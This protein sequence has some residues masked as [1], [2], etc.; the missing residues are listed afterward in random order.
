MAIIGLCMVAAPQALKRAIFD[1]RTILG[2]IAACAI[3]AIISSILNNMAPVRLARQVIEIH[4]QAAASIVVGACMIRVCG[5][6]PTFVMFATV[7]GLST[8]LALLQFLN[9]GQ[10]WAIRDVFQ[11]MQPMQTA[12]DSVFL[13]LR[14]RAMGLS[15]S[16]VHLGTQL[17]LLFAA[18]FAL[19]STTR[20]RGLLTTFDMRVGLL[21]LVLVFGCVISGN[22]SPLIGIA[23]FMIAYLFTVKP[24]IALTLAVVALPLVVF[25][26]DIMAVLADFGLRVARTD[27]GSAAGRAILRAFGV[28]LFFDRPYGYG[29][30]F[31]SVEHWP[32]YWETLS[33]YDNPM[34]IRIHALHNYY[35]MILNKYGAPVVIVA[36]YICSKIVR[37]KIAMLAFTPYA[38]HIFYHNEGPMQGDFLIW[39]ILPMFL[40]IY[41]SRERRPVKQ[42][43][44]QS[45][46]R[47]E[48]NPT[49][50]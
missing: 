35:L 31:Q 32:K 24:A 19:L 25:I 16:P 37:N 29:L 20:G 27:D 12:E 1:V 22:R 4:V 26:D 28:L 10:A 8:A 17:C 6:T 41:P 18:G 50:G 21:A 48:F 44:R 42:I 14:L 43:A 39:F 2:V 34:A 38:V 36:A 47:R 45:H 33:G 11:R 13:T 30:A 5:R 9:V 46:R 49:E 23:V 40:T 15:F 3:I 7:I